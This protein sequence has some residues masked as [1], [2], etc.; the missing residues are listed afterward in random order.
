MAD[1]RSGDAGPVIRSVEFYNIELAPLAD[2]R[3]YVSMLA[4]TVDE[5]EPQLLT[6]EIARDTVATVE[7]AL[8]V[9]RQ[10]LEGPVP[11]RSD[12]VR[13]SRANNH[14]PSAIPTALFFWYDGA[15]PLEKLDR[16]LEVL[17]S[18]E[19]D[20]LARLNFDRFTGCGVASIRA[21][22]LRTCRMPRP[23][24]RMRLPFFRCFVHEADRTA[25][26]FFRLPLGHFMPLGER[27]SDGS[28]S[29]ARP[30]RSRGGAA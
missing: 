9:I 4:T 30:H 28:S 18:A 19:R 10:G 15:R 17:R 14:E 6:Q 16:F 27:P 21:A 26:Y 20:F 7:D 5:E 1:P 8:A 29:T 11:A 23:A 13:H 2:G 25:E 22:R 3:V 24:I 12:P